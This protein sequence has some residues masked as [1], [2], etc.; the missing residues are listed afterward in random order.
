[1]RRKMKDSEKLADLYLKS[2]GVGDVQFEPDGNIPP[3]FAIDARI[4][5]EVRRLNQNFGF[6]DGSTQGLEECTIPLLQWFKANLPSLGP[7]I[8]GESW[9]VGF[10]FRRPLEEL[11]KLRPLVETHLRR[12]KSQTVR[13]RTSIQVTP[14]L[15]L[16]LDQAEKDWGYFFLLGASG[17]DDSGGLVM[18]ELERNLGLCIA[19]KERKIEPYRSKYPEWWLVLADY[20]DYSMDPKDRLTFRA[21]VMPRLPNRFNKIVLID[22]RDHRRA[23]VAYTLP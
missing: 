13:E 14:N 2:L 7:S 9:F 4:A 18:K 10:D 22:P 11:G 16:H 23:F 15:V 3:D 6:G 1:M 17:D 20:I 21:E 12:F 19:E 8:N 5:V